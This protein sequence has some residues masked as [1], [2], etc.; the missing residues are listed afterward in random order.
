MNSCEL[1]GMGGGEASDGAYLVEEHGSCDDG[2]DAVA[3]GE[4]SPDSGKAILWGED[5]QEGNHEENLT[6]QT[7]EDGF[8]GFAETLEEVGGDNL[9]S[10]HPEAEGG[11]G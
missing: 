11:D 10:Y 2:G 4:A 5:Y 3:D 1:R 7:E 8:A 9:E 6:G